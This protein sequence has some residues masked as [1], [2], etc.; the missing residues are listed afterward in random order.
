MAERFV[1]NTYCEE[2][3]SE[4]GSCSFTVEHIVCDEWLVQ[5]TCHTSDCLLK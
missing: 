3:I 1:K 5:V 2:S 4:D